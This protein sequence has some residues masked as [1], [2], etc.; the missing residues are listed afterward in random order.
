M[1]RAHPEYVGFRGREHEPV[2]PEDTPLIAVTCS[3]CGRRRNVPSGL[4]QG[5]VDSY[6]CQS[7]Q[8]P[9]EIAAKEGKG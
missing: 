6:V 8:E 3:R 5:K 7:C 1:K 2:N 9:E 4:V